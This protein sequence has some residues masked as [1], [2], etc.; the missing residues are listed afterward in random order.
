MIEKEEQQEKLDAHRAKYRE[1]KGDE[2]AVDATIEK[3]N[4]DI[5][6]SH[7]RIAIA[8]DEKTK[9]EATLVNLG[10]QMEQLQ[11]DKDQEE[12]KRDEMKDL[13][14]TKDEDNDVHL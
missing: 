13:S 4:K 2:K 10:T 3:T 6:D 7:D 11:K 5:T 1:L 8:Q 12:K 9:A 14:V